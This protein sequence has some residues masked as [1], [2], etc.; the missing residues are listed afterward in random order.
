MPAL[1]ATPEV[2][3]PPPRSVGHLP[4]HQ[5]RNLINAMAY[6]GHRGTPMTLHASIVWRYAANFD[7]QHWM[8]HQGRVFESL[9]RWLARQGQHDAGFW[10]REWGRDKEEHTHLVLHLAPRLRDDLRQHLLQAGGFQAQPDD[11][12]EP[13]LITPDPRDRCS[14][15]RRSMTNSNQRGGLLRYLLK[16]VS[17]LAYLDGERVMPAL[18]I[19]SRGRKP[20]TIVGK[21]SGV[22]HSIGRSARAAAGWHEL[23]TVPEMRA[24]LHPKEARHH[25]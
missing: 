8:E 11:G 16:H 21:R 14:R 25:A 22:S 5:V 18:G 20:C 13:I 17:P 19:D 3:S 6:A 7:P 4:L 10:V 9:K 12:N 23:V 2:A 15:G 24:V 1:Q